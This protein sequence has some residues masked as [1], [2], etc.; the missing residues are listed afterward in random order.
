M[1]DLKIWLCE[2][3]I[4][5]N[6]E[7]QEQNKDWGLIKGYYEIFQFSEHINYRSE[8]ALK[9]EGQKN[10]HRWDE[11]EFHK[12]YVFLKLCHFLLDYFVRL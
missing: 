1:N 7:I 11:Y 3:D 8:P 2:F 10:H 4:C 6:D 9:Y 12:R 5:K